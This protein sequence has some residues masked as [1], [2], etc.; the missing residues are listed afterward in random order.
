MK[1]TRS[2]SDN[3]VLVSIISI[4]ICSIPKTKSLDACIFTGSCNIGH[5]LGEVVK[6]ANGNQN[7]RNDPEGEAPV[8]VSGNWIESASLE[9]DQ[10][11]LFAQ[12]APSMTWYDAERYCEDKGAFLAEPFFCDQYILSIVLSLYFLGLQWSK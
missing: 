11:Y 4:L 12:D 10:I 1:S 9:T 5:L 3:I 2:V 8:V 7:A 6:I